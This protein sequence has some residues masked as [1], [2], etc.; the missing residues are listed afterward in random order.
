[1]NLENNLPYLKFKRIDI[2]HIAKRL[3]E[4][5]SSIWYLDTSRQANGKGPHYHTTSIVINHCDGEP[6]LDKYNSGRIFN[7][8][9][10]T[11]DNFVSAV[12]NM[13]KNIVDE[14]LNAFTDDIVKDL[15]HQ[16]DGYVAKTT[17]AKLP[18]G[19][20]ITPH[21][22][23]GYYLSTV[24]RLHIPIITNDKVLFTVGGTTFHMEEGV[25][26]ELNNRLMHSVKN[27]G[28]SDRIHLIVD[29]I[30]KDKYP[31]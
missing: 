16:F 21:V 22:D 12:K 27:L 23:P 30:P 19:K 26:Y 10:L 4:L 3:L 1:M 2:S 20:E 9:E 18:A 6:E 13:K 15:E 14:H 24:H 8:T 17:Y 28:D 7:V 5:E 31:T 29:I 25:L 11:Y